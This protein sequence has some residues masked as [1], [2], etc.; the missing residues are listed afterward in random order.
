[1]KNLPEVG[2]GGGSG[3]P[4]VSVGNK[5]NKYQRMDSDAEESQ[6][7]REAEARNS[8][9][10]KYVMACAFFASLNN[11]LL[12]YGRF[13]LYNRI[14]LLLLYFVDLQKGMCALF[15][16]FVRC[17]GNERCGVVHTAGSQNNGGADGSAHW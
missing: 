13:Y 9:T 10:R 4:A 16:V 17:W 15:L 3:F 7:H 11:V 5:K 1:M 12:G 14:L 8:R 6:N 2:N